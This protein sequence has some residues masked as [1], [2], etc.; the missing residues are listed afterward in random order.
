MCIRQVTSIH[1]SQIKSLTEL[2]Y[3][4]GN[5][6]FKPLL[7]VRSLTIINTLFHIKL[8]LSNICLHVKSKCATLK[9][10]RM[11][12]NSVHWM[13]NPLTWHVDPANNEIK[14]KYMVFAFH[15]DTFINIFL[16]F[17]P[18]IIYHSNSPSIG[19]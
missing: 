13:Q 12:K 16:Q 3:K 17:S 14:G 4:F 5:L 1:W 19:F 18:K 7:R 2:L 11:I 15:T 10:T 9:Y 6:E 8:Y